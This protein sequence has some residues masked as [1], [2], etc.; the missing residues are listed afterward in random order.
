MALIASVLASYF[1]EN[2]LG[3]PLFMSA[4]TIQLISVLFLHCSKRPKFAEWT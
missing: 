1:K 4:C 3:F 2:K